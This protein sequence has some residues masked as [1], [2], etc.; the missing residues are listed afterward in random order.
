M[1]VIGK[2]DLVEINDWKQELELDVWDKLV[3]YRRDENLLSI[4]EQPP[5]KKKI[6]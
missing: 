6:N 1:L 2:C 5:L 3:A 4:K